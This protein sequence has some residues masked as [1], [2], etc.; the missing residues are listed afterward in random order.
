LRKPGRYT[1]RVR[2]TA[3]GTAKAVT[4]KVKIARP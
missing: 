4:L 1:I 2:A 3:S